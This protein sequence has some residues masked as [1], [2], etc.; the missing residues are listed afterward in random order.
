[1]IKGTKRKAVFT[2]ITCDHA[3]E[4]L[5]KFDAGEKNLQSYAA[6][7]LRRQLADLDAGLKPSCHLFGSDNENAQMEKLL[8]KERKSARVAI[9]APEGK[10]TSVK[11]EL[12]LSRDQAMKLLLAWEQPDVRAG[13]EWNGYTEE[14]IDQIK[15][16]LGPGFVKF[17]YLLRE[18]IAE[19]SPE[20]DRAMRNQFGA[21]LPPIVNYFPTSYEQAA[22]LYADPMLGESYGNLSVAPGF[23]IARKFHLAAPD[24]TASA[25]GAFT[26]NQ[27]QSAH[28]LE[29]AEPV[30]DFRAVLKNPELAAVI[31][32]TCGDDVYN[33]ICDRIK[34]IARGGTDTARGAELI[35][36]L[37]K[38]W[39]PAK[40]MANLS[41]VAKQIAGSVNF[42]NTIPGGAY[43]SG[44]ADFF[45]GS[46]LAKRFRQSIQ[47]E[48]AD[49][50][51]DRLAGGLD[52]N[53]AYLLNPARNIARYSPVANRIID[54]GTLPTRLA[55]KF[56]SVTGGYAVFKYHYKQLLKRGT[57]DAQAWDQAMQKMF[58]AI[59]E[60]QQSGYLKDQNRFQADAKIWRY[61][62]TFLTNPVQVMNLELQ[63]LNGLATGTGERRAEARERMV[64]QIITNHVI[65]PVAMTMIA[66]FLSHG[67]D[68]DEYDWEDFLTA[69]LAGPFEG[70]LI[71]GKVMP[72]I[73]EN[74]ISVMRGKKSA[75]I[76]AFNISI[77]ALPMLDEAGRAT[78]KIA[79][80]ATRKRALQ[81]RDYLAGAKAA[82]ELAVPLSAI[83]PAA[84]AISASG[85]AGAALIREL[86]RLYDVTKSF[87]ETTQKKRKTTR[88]RRK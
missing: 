22:G 54:I 56:A 77:S 27:I 40:I 45:S 88:K 83:A 70:W 12:V 35:S 63:T 5:A 44:V 62:T 73:A 26:S 51:K 61:L 86:L 15:N 14:T 50:F 65:A 10:E 3:R 67:K 36:R 46:D 25:I 24:P 52:P 55:D 37:F 60:T 9:I 80:L 19:G 78:A 20:I 11:T 31:R 38:V 85:A 23:L 34:T 2:Y 81:T 82:G 6:E 18:A 57:P 79:S 71:M 8:E 84:A 75:G 76:A 58:R 64:R 74:L 28:Y 72:A 68:F 43:V 39:T 49:Y 87:D 48:Y 16:F 53:L 59:D 7:F 21:G 69:M 47:T 4:A 29:F 13:M 32:R 41:S 1:E 66:Q 17:A 33:E 30:R 42:I